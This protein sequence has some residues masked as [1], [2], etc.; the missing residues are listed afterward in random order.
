MGLFNMFDITHDRKTVK[1]L[2]QHAFFYFYFIILAYEIL[3]Q[4]YVVLIFYN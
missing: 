1:I 4:N 2:I 3:I